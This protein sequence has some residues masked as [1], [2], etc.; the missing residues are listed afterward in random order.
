MKTY[1]IAAGVGTLVAVLGGVIY[2]ISD[3]KYGI[4]LLAGGLIAAIMGVVMRLVAAY[5]GDESR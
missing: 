4:V 5:M 3:H 1:W 2:V